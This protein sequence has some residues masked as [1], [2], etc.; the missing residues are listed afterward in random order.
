M[1]LA[2]GS[3]FGILFALVQFALISVWFGYRPHNLTYVIGGL[4]II[5]LVS[6]I[7]IIRDNR[8]LSRKP[9]S[10]LTQLVSGEASEEYLSS[11]DSSVLPLLALDR[12]GPIALII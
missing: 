5:L 3:K 11:V 4:V 9:N 1:Q 12:I 2:G 8:S 6:S 7:T 10:L